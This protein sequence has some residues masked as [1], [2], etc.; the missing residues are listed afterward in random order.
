MLFSML[1]IYTRAIIEPQILCITQCLYC[2]Y[3]FLIQKDEPIK[4]GKAEESKEATTNG[5]NEEDD[6]DDLD[7]DDI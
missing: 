3:H 1:S 5:N 6:D 2:F 7:I 4:N